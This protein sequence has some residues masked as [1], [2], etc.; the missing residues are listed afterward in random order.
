MLEQQTL[1]LRPWAF[2]ADQPTHS[3]R[4]GSGGAGPGARTRVVLAG[5]SGAPLGFAAWRTAPGVF[6]KRWFFRPVLEVFETEDASL[7]MTV[8]APR[9]LGRDWEVRDAE[10]HPAGVLRGDVVLDRSGRALAAAE[11]D[12]AGAGR[13][14]VTPLGSVLTTLTPAGDGMLL[15]FAP[16]LEGDPF[17]RMVLLAAALVD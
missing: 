9:R 14:F 7:L 12:P 10:G 15:T 16:G 17:A 3:A 11:P 13:R 8:A 1:L 2:P 5:A 4:A 6:W